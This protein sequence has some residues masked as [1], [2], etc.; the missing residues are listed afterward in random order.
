MLS[1]ANVKLCRYAEA[2]PLYERRLSVFEKA[3]GPDHP[4]VAATLNGM[5]GLLRSQGRYV[6]I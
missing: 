2:L 4:N 5:A 1:K 6:K 3:L